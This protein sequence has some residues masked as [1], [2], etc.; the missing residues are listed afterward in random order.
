MS[1]TP[2]RRNWALVAWW[3][4]PTGI[5]LLCCGA[6]LFPI[7]QG[8]KVASDK[9]CL[10]NVRQLALSMVMYSNDYDDRL[11]EREKWYD[12]SMLFTKQRYRCP[13][14]PES[15]NGASTV[16]F[17]FNSRLDR[18]DVVKAVDPQDTVMLYDSVDLLP[19]ASDPVTSVPVD[20][21]H[22][23]LN[24][25]GYMDGHAKAYPPSENPGLTDPFV[26]PRQ[27][28]SFGSGP[29]KPRG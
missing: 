12:A 22:N 6:V 29:V 1:D 11:P 25:F 21:R 5:A 18:L 23:G 2:R 27:G 13:K 14:V 16:G 19:N 28:R 24:C 9:D 7:F 3:A 20:P 8:A 26:S 15:I 10:S 17:A 4:I